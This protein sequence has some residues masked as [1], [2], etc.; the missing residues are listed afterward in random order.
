MF[1]SSWSNGRNINGQS[2]DYQYV[3]AEVSWIAAE[4]LLTGN[5]TLRISSNANWEETAVG[6]FTSTKLS[7]FF[8]TLD[9]EANLT[10]DPIL[11]SLILVEANWKSTGT[12]SNT[13]SRVKRVNATLKI[14]GDS[15]FIGIAFASKIPA[16]THRCF[17][18]EPY[19]ATFYVDDL[20]RDIAA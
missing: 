12:V 8:A 18:V 7:K 2:I 17:K 3:V 13:F 1:N 9:G 5:S 19:V 15:T 14:L 6:S 20:Y 10:V 11:T 4:S 16:P